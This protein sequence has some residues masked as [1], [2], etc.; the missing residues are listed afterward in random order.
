MT[1]LCWPGDASNAAKLWLGPPPTVAPLTQFA[2]TNVVTATAVVGD[3]SQLLL[4]LR[5]RPTVEI[6]TQAG[7]TFAKNQIAIRLV[8]RGDV[9]LLH[10]TAFCSL[11][12]ITS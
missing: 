12:G 4:G 1:W 9:A 7:N 6:S 5:R 3:F 10:E 2:S 8:W 11:T